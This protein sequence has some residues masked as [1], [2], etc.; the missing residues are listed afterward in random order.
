[1]EWMV[2]CS[3][4]AAE[5]SRE[6]ELHSLLSLAITKFAGDES[7]AGTCTA[8]W[9]ASEAKNRLCEVT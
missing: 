1:M 2:V 9:N 7:N 8:L 3:S 4:S 6:E 5:L